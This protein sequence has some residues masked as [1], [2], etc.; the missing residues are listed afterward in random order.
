MFPQVISG[1]LVAGEDK[2]FR[3]VGVV[4]NHFVEMLTGVQHFS[5][6]FRGVGGDVT[7]V[8]EGPHCK[9]QDI[10]RGGTERALPRRRWR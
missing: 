4:A 3:Q 6:S 2:A 5:H 10:G 8:E 7:I 9:S 1:A